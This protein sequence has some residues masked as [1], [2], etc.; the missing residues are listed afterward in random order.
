MSLDRVSHARLL[1]EVISLRVSPAQVGDALDGGWDR[2][3]PVATLTADNL[4]RALDGFLAGELD[5]SAVADW[6]DFFEVRDDVDFDSTAVAD[7]IFELANP[8]LEGRLNA[9]RA[10]ELLRALG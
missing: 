2:D 7:A 8:A 5:S 4:R 3:M 10:R 1:Y 6:A 9:E